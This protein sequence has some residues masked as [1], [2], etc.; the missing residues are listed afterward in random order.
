MSHYCWAEQ[1]ADRCPWPQGCVGGAQGA[2]WKVGSRESRVGIWGRCKPQSRSEGS[3]P[4]CT[5]GPRPLVDT[6]VCCPDPTVREDL[7][8]PLCAPAG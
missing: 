5:A 6:E 7:L 2:V 3:E 8:P 1:E 4:R